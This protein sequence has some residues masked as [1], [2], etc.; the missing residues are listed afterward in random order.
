MTWNADLS[1]CP[2]DPARERLS[3]EILAE[4]HDTDWQRIGLEYYDRLTELMGEAAFAIWAAPYALDELCEA[5]R[6]VAACY[7]LF[8]KINEL[9]GW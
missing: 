5:G 4:A 9:E 2:A 3:A 7:R 8:E 1:V 6:H